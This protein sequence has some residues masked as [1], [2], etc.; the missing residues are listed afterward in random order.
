VRANLEPLDHLVLY[1]SKDG[2]TL[3]FSGFLGVD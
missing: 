3:K 1:G 2:R